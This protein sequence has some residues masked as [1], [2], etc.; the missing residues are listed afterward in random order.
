MVSVKNWKTFHVFIF[1]KTK[2]E[3]VFED[4]LGKKKKLF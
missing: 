2:Q 4:I 1:V 3:N